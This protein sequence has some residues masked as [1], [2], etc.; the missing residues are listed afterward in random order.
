MEEK[1]QDGDDDEDSSK[2]T[3]AESKKPLKRR[4]KRTNYNNLLLNNNTHNFN[5]KEEKTMNSKN[6]LRAYQR[7]IYSFMKSNKEICEKIL[8]F[9]LTQLG[10]KRR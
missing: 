3:S 10:S 2:K 8:G 1:N 6:V 5:D 7:A 4:R 9:S